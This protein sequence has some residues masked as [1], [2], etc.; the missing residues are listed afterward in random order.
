MHGLVICMGLSLAPVYRCRYRW[1]CRC[2]CQY[3]W[4]IER[5][6]YQVICDVTV[7]VMAAAVLLITRRPARNSPL[8]GLPDVALLML[9][10][11]K[12]P[13]FHDDIFT[14]DD[15]HHHHGSA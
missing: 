15:P 9:V 4:Y 3:R 8:L 5:W 14:I 11:R 6:S 13:C 7:S 10:L 2:Q 1:L 12:I